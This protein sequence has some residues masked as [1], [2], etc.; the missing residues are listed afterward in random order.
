MVARGKLIRPGADRD[1]AAA[2][3]RLGGRAADQLP[4]RGMGLGAPAT[5]DL[6]RRSPAEARACGGGIAVGAG[7]DQL[8]AGNHSLDAVTAAYAEQLALADDAG[9]QPIL[10]A[11]RALCAAAS[12]PDDYHRVYGSLLEQAARPV[13]LHWLGDK[14]DPALAGYWGSASL[15]TAADVVV[16]LITTNATKVDGIKVSLLDT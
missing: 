8:A 14:F 5:R 6:I 16:E 2:R 12:G 4:Q 7:T 1:P 13:I 11:S 9:A 10:M 3:P 15:D